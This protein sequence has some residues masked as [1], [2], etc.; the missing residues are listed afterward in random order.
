MPSVLLCFRTDTSDAGLYIPMVSDRILNN[1]AEVQAHGVNL[2]GF[3]IG[4]GCP[5]WDVLTCTPYSCGHTGG[6][7]AGGGTE[8]AVDFRFG[9]GFASQPTYAQYDIFHHP[10]PF[11]YHP[12]GLNQEKDKIRV[13][14]L[15]VTST[16]SG[17]AVPW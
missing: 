7:C 5:G 1:T 4:N 2:Q 3:M 9:H 12:L 13:A 14:F 17:I 8:V 6:I 16:S 11:R 10:I 15:S